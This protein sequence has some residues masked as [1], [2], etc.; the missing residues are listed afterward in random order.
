M[1]LFDQAD[2]QGAV[3]VEVLDAADAEATAAADTKP[4]EAGRRSCAL[5]PQ[6]RTR[7]KKRRN[8]MTST[9]SWHPME[10]VLVPGSTDTRRVAFEQPAGG[11]AVT[12]DFTSVA[13]TES[14]NTSLSAWNPGSR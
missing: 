14:S 5:N 2:G 7:P 8:C 11:A 6:T 10:P 13:P 4:G 9:V 1:I 3:A 12:L